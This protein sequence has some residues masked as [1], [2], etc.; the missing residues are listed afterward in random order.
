MR[1][2]V[3]S[4]ALGCLVIAAPLGAQRSG[5]GSLSG[6][7]RE[8]IDSRSVR[9]ASVSLV[10]MHSEAAPT[11]TAR[12]DAHGKYRLDSLPAG[13]YLVQVSSPT[14]DS[15]ELSM[16]ADRIEIPA[17]SEARY[18]ATLPSGAKLRDAICNGAR[19]DDGRIVVAGHAIDADTDR[20]LVGAQVVASWVYNYIDRTTLK[21]VTQT[22]TASVKTDSDGSYRMCGVPSDV[23]LS[24]QLQREQR[25]G[26]IVRLVVSDEEGAAVRDM[27]LS[28]RTAPTAAELDSVAR[29]RG[30][31]GRDSARAELKLVG[32]ATLSGVVRSLSGEP[33]RDAEIRVRDAR[34]STTT[35][36]AGAF[37]LSGLPAGTQLLVVRRLGVPPVEQLVDLRPERTVR[38]EVLVGRV[39]ALDSI[40][41]VAA[42][43]DYPEFERNRRSNAFGQFLTRK[44]ITGIQATETADLFFD[45]LGFS[46]FGRGTQ[47]RIVSNRA[48]SRHPECKSA[49]VVID[50]MENSAI[51]S[52]TPSEIAGI[53]AYSDETFVPARFTGRAECGVIVIWRRKTE[54]K[55]MPPMGLSGN[56]YP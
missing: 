51:W 46:V 50:G 25:V 2:L 42:R 31:S 49:N 13:R 4:V 38:R 18:D 39:I 6:V 30:G 47:A 32:T 15:L 33:V 35:D 9:S 44:Q 3:G 7:I 26:P 19:M 45:I 37:T 12:P 55:V 17:G 5:V 8:T 22:R 23:V 11:F 14:L 41:V 24:L 34:A 48:L 1:A 21:V 29:V 40:R 10:P 52:I 36:S 53:E 27:S 54:R 20:P 43:T 28:P 16:P 56:G